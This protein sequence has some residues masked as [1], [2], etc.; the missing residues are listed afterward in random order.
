M[1]KE[2]CRVNING[3]EKDYDVRFIDENSLSLLNT[4]ENLT[5][6]FAISKDTIHIFVNGEKYTVKE[7][8]GDSDFGG[9]G[10]GSVQE[11]GLVTT[12]M[13]G[14]IIKFLVKEGDVVEVDQGLVIVEAMKM[15]NEIRSTIKGKVV[16]LNFQAGDAVDVGI[17]IID[18]EELES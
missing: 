4:E 14:T 12:P 11:K 16:K 8:G 9:A 17:P 18:L 3:A 7:T 5:V 10:A 13:P 1:S 15:E 2:S 6:Y